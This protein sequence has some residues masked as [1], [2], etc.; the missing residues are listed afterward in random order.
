MSGPCELCE[1]RALAKSVPVI[2]VV[3]V[4]QKAHTFRYFKFL[5][6]VTLENQLRLLI[7]ETGWQRCLAH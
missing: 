6:V 4:P 7:P 1:R 5:N 2:A 3:D